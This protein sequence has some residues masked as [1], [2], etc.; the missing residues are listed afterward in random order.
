MFSIA[1]IVDETKDPCSDAFQMVEVGMSI[2]GNDRSTLCG[3]C[4]VTSLLDLI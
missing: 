2:K 4:V 3:S 1:T